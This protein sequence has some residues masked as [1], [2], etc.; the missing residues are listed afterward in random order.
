LKLLE[1]GTLI[2][3]NKSKDIDEEITLV[4]FK[5]AGHR[6]TG[7]QEAPEKASKVK[8]LFKCVLCASEFPAEALLEAHEKHTRKD[9]LVN[10]VLK[11]LMKNKV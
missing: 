2:E 11:F 10:I 7:P 3:E 4:G 6:R 9:I 8:D 1:E 5:N